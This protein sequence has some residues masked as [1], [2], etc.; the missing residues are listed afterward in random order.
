M[1]KNI[2]LIIG[3]TIPLVMILV[4]AGS[5]YLPSLFVSPKYDFIY[6]SSASYSSRYTYAVENE[7]L[8]R[9]E[10][11]AEER[12]MS[13]TIFDEK[14]YYYGIEEN[15][16]REISFDEASRLNLVS[17]YKSPDGFEISYGSS[18]DGIFPFFPRSSRDRYLKGNGVA[19]K[20]NMEAGNIYAYDFQFIGWVKK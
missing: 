6:I 12:S 8:I 2:T 5:I 4:V 10:R 7:K 17:S 14:I 18:G 11:P 9:T 13:R 3:L 19:K 15:K 1:K 20:L 16:S